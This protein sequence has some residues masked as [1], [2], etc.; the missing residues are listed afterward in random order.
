M[1]F[2]PL[3]LVKSAVVALFFVVAVALWA[4]A[5]QRVFWLLCAGC[6][7]AGFGQGTIHGLHGVCLV[8]APLSNLAVKRDAVLKRVAPYF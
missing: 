5:V 6:R 2:L 7:H 8:L 3:A 1:P 4:R